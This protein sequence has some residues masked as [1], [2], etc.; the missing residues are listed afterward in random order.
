ML[1]CS[2]ATLG[3]VFSAATVSQS[4]RCRSTPGNIDKEKLVFVTA[5]TSKHFK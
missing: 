5:D 2:A 3:D 4:H 1:V